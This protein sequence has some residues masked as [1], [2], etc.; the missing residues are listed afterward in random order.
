MSKKQRQ[1]VPAKQKDGRWVVAGCK[2]AKKHARKCK[3]WVQWAERSRSA[4]HV[5]ARV[6]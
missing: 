2:P 4:E 5:V 6:T 3:R 1:K